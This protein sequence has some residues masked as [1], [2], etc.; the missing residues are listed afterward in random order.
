MNRLLVPSMAA[1]A[2]LA[3]V[4]VGTVLA[5]AADD[6][7]DRASSTPPLGVTTS[8]TG[9]AVTTP[10]AF[11]S[12]SLRPAP[13]VTDTSDRPPSTQEPSWRAKQRE[14]E[15]Q[16]LSAEGQADSVGAVALISLDPSLDVTPGSAPAAFAGAS[17][18]PS[19][20]RVVLE[21]G[22]TPLRGVWAG[23]ADDLARYLLVSESS[24]R[25][26]VPVMTLAGYYVRYAAEVGLRADVLWAQMLHETGFGTFGGSVKPEQNNFAGLGATGGGAQG[27]TFPTAEAGVKAHIAHMVAYAFTTDQAGW[28]NASTDPRY[29]DVSPRGVAQTLSDLDGRWAVPGNGYGVAIERHVRT[30]NSP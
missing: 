25:F 19:S 18:S 29:D 12:A 21:N 27:L 5:L 20:T 28:T 9:T 16:M 23:T 10:P 14:A 2:G 11:G 4:A 24:P 17:G 6:S 13:A 26:T 15:Q 1:L 3:L 30:V 8:V 22:A 7:G